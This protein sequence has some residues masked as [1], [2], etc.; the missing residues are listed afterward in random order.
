MERF[1]GGSAP[2]GPSD[3]AAQGGVP[4]S[5][6]ETG[7]RAR[8]LDRHQLATD[9]AC[10]LAALGLSA[11][12]D[13]VVRSGGDPCIVDVRTTRIGLARSIASRLLVDRI[14]P[15]QPIGR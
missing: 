9:E 14:Q 7:A 12:C 4:L 15:I 11:G 5:G 3:G 10:L 8:L 6:L 13:F 2:Q 1:P